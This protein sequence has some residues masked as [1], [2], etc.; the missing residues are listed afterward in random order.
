M[1][2][3]D[4]SDEMVLSWWPAPAGRAPLTRAAILDATI[5]QIDRDGLDAFS[6]RK[7]ATAL[8][9][10]PPALYVHVR[11]K[12]ELFALAFDS[13]VA[14][15]ALPDPDSTDWAEGLRRIARSW[16]ATML[17][18][19]G[20]TQLSAAGMPLGPN[21]LRQTDTVFGLLRRA[22]LTGRDVVSVGFNFSCYCMG[23]S[24]FVDA[25]NPVRQLE[26][27]GVS[28]EVALAQWADMLS[29]LPAESIPNVAAVAE[30]LVVDEELGAEM[31]DTALEVFIDGVRARLTAARLMNAR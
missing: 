28:Y 26:R 15:V 7:V 16:R 10:T 8:G 22:G 29:A 17:A 20:A 11:N 21:L 18:H 24:L 4:A 9:V 2:N 5:D 30:H 27:A 23:F 31:F 19:P 14:Q 3:Q 6:M 12:E 1:T 13:V 25:N